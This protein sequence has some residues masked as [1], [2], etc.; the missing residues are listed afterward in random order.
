MLIIQCFNITDYIAIISQLR[1]QQPV[2]TTHGH[3]VICFSFKIEQYPTRKIIKFYYSQEF[4]C[5]LV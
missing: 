5:I 1:K 2:E 4:L 3:S